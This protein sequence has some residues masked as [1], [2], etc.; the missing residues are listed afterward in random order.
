MT[1]LAIAAIVVRDRRLAAAEDL[2]MRRSDCAMLVTDPI[3]REQA[4]TAASLVSGRTTAAASRSKL[5][6]YAVTRSDDIA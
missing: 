5:R 4:P 3:R 6:W 1:K 2:R